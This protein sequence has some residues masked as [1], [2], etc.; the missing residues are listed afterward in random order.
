MNSRRQ[1]LAALAS[2]AIAAYPWP[3]F[4]RSFPAR[5]RQ[6]R[7]IV[8]LPP[9]GQADFQARLIAPRLAA[10]LGVPV[11]VDNRPGASSIIGLQEV[12][13]AVP[14]GHTLL[15]TIA[16]PIV[17]NPHLF[18]KL[19]YDP[20]RD[21]V[22]ITLTA[23][24]AQALIAHASVPVSNVRDLVVYAKANP[25]ELNF[26]SYGLG[27]SS[28]MYGEMLKA[29]AGIDIVHVP[30]KGAGDVLKDL[31]AG[32]VQLVFMALT[33]ALA[34]IQS[35]NLKV[36]G[37]VGDKRITAMPEVRTFLEQGISGLELVGWLG[38]FAPAGTPAAIVLRLN[39]DV[40]GILRQPEIVERFRQAGSDARGMSVRQFSDLIRSDYDR[41]GVVVRRLRIRLD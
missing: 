24:T 32:R 19:P 27:T 5:H 30:Y 39:A 34:H 1:T 23:V 40:A 38:M 8:P 41:W 22:P 31:V 10:A 26:G 6:V 11:V 3:A 20:L 25:G 13:R 7:M 33:S 14:D 4:A 21:L 2:S 12:V 9:G 17:V 28:H 16:S 36:L 35:G 18:A 29:S 15:Y 37:V